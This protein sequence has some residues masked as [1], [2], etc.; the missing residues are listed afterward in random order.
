MHLSYQHLE[1]PPLT[2]EEL[3]LLDT[4]LR[5]LKPDLSLFQV[6]GFLCA[7]LTTPVEIPPTNYF[8]AML[9]PDLPDIVSEEDMQLYL[10]MVMQLKIELSDSLSHDSAPC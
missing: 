8:P 6:H 3:T 7:V 10:D 2:Q 5:A 1:L 9:V 4:W